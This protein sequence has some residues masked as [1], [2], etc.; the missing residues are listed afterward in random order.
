MCSWQCYNNYYVHK[1]KRLITTG[2]ELFLNSHFGHGSGPILFTYLDC[3]GTES[4]LSDCSTYS[5]HYF[6]AR[7][8]DDAGVRCQRAT[9]TSKL[10]I[11]MIANLIFVTVLLARADCANGDVRLM[12]G[13]TPYEGRVEICYD[14]VWGS[15]CDSGWNDQDAAIVCLQLE[16]QGA[17]N[18]VCYNN[19]I[20]VN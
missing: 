15:V 12:N 2:V 10:L 19:I 3:D 13:T 8:T 17:S 18:D 5:S 1:F 9:T 20:V 11:I 16:F 7:H 14:G 4:R 6:G